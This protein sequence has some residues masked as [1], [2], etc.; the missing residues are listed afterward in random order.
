MARDVV[1]RDRDDADVSVGVVLLDCD[2]PPFPGLD[3]GAVVAGL[4]E[5]ERACVGVVVERVAAAVDAGQAERRRRLGNGDAHVS[6]SSSC[7]RLGIGEA[8]PS[9]RW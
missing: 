4:H 5:H 9:A 6:A 8:R 2:Q 1:R 7:S 3:V